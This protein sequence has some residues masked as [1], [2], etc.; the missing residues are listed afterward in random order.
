MAQLSSF[1][2]LGDFLLSFTPLVSA[3]YRMCGR[4]GERFVVAQGRIRRGR[5]E[6]NTDARSKTKKDSKNNIS[7][8]EAA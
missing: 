1:L 3:S 8:Q 5:E 2:S 7:V 4:K 6:E